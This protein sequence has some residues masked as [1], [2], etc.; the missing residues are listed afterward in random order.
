M[1][2]I[3]RNHGFVT[4]VP[5]HPLDH[6]WTPRGYWTAHIRIRELS[7]S[8]V[9]ALLVQSSQYRLVEA[10]TG[11]QLRWYPRGNYGFWHHHAK[12]TMKAPTEGP[13]PLRYTASEWTD[14]ETGECVILFQQQ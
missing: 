4:L 11:A 9:D 7:V 2:S 8:E 14:A 6:L 1:K 13:P 12:L 5:E 3:Q 10:R